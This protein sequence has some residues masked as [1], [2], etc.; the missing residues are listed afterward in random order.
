MTA[1]DVV[2]ALETEGVVF[3]ADVK[4]EIAEG[5]WLLAAIDA[6]YLADEQRLRLSKATISAVR[7]WFRGA[8]MRSSMRA[9]VEPYLARVEKRAAKTAA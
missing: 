1:V 7:D 3:D 5:A 4:R 6:I 2:H 9:T 8:S